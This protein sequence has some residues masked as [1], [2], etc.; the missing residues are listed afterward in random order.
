MEIWIT[1]FCVKI[2]FQTPLSLFNNDRRHELL[3]LKKKRKIDII[4]DLV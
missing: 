4:E 1:V 3:I 2:F